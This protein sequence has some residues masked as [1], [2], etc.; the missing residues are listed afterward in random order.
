MAM[1][2][3]GLVTCTPCQYQCRFG[4]YLGANAY[5]QLF[6]RDLNKNAPPSKKLSEARFF[7]NGKAI[8]SIQK[9]KTVVEMD[10]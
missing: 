3:S 6:V 7:Q 2:A 8:F 4:K 9:E 1:V 5:N 10:A